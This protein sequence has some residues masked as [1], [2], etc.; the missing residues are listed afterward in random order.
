MIRTIRHFVFICVFIPAFLAVIFISCGTSPSSGSASTQSGKDQRQRIYMDYVR[1]EGYVPSID[2]DGDILFKKEG[3]S[4][5]IIIGKNDTSF[6]Q[7]LLPNIWSIDS[8]T[9]RAQVAEAI[10]YANRRTKVAKA[11]ISGARNQ[12]VSIGVETF[13]EDPTHFGPL[14]PRMMNAISTANENFEDQMK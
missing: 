2:E 6:M 11:Y 14:F 3:R 12:W 4:Y 8:E 10:S 7:L 13:F 9:E 1:A 5:F